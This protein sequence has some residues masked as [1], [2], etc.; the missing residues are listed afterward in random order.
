MNSADEGMGE[1]AAGEIGNAD[2]DEEDGGPLGLEDLD[3]LLRIDAE[4][5][6]KSLEPDAADDTFETFD[7]IAGEW[8]AVNAEEDDGP[9]EDVLLA[10][11]AKLRSLTGVEREIIEL[12]FGFGDEEPMSVQEIAEHFALEEKRVADLIRRALR[13]MRDR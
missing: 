6:P 5:E 2:Y 13:R 3:M 8:F 7:E 1:Q 9:S 10:A 12:R 11:H 4:V